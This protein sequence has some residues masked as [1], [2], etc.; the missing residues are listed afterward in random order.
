MSKKKL[1]IFDEF[2]VEFPS[3][4]KKFVTMSKSATKKVAP[5]PGIAEAIQGLD[6]DPSVK[7]KL[8]EEIAA[9]FYANLKIVTRPCSVC[10]IKDDAPLKFAVVI[11][12]SR[13]GTAV[14]VP[15]RDVTSVNNRSEIP[16]AYIVPLRQLANEKT[17][18]LGSEKTSKVC[19]IYCAM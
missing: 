16:D 8:G 3:I 12:V 6:L 5:I 11:R 9:G 2:Q 10:K 4:L 1:T 14:Y 7:R 17:V 19:F 18:L 13:A 15:S